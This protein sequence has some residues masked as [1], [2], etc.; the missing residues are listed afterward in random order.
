MVEGKYGAQS[1]RDGIAKPV[2]HTAPR[3]RGCDLDPIR[4][5][6][7]GPAA[8]ERPHQRSN[9]CQHLTTRNTFPKIP[10]ASAEASTDVKT[11][12]SA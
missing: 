1:M 10:L 11:P 3:A 6:P 5:L 8:G 12:L 7:Y 2:F 4:E 9:R